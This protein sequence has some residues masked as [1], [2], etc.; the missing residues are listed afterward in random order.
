MVLSGRAT[1]FVFGAAKHVAPVEHN[2]VCRHLLPHAFAPF[3]VAVC[4]VKLGGRIDIGLA[5]LRVDLN[6]AAHHPPRTGWKLRQ[7]EKNST[8]R[9]RAENRHPACGV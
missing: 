3:K 9:V 2:A 4:I 1:N 7:I 8:A 5:L 6:L